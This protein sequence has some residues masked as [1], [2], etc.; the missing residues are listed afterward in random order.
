M[1]ASDTKKRAVLAMAG[2]ND[3]QTSVAVEEGL[4]AAGF[5]VHPIDLAADAPI[6]IDNAA[7]WLLDLR[8]DEKLVG[9]KPRLARVLSGFALQHSK[10]DIDLLPCGRPAIG[11]GIVGAGNFV[12]LSLWVRPTCMGV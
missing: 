10:S 5:S 4:V 6:P 3:A 9:D 11:V 7:A 2:Q 1:F 8:K 12:E